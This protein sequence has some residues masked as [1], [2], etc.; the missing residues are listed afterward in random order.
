MR[1]RCSNARRQGVC[2]ASRRQRDG[3]TLERSSLSVPDRDHDAPCLEPVR[4]RRVIGDR[5]RRSRSQHIERRTGGC[6]GLV[7]R[8]ENVILPDGRDLE[9]RERAQPRDD[10]NGREARQ[11]RLRCVGSELDLD[12]ATRSGHAISLRVLDPYL[13]SRQ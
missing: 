7:S 1:V 13:E 8:D 6:H 5:E 3:L 10:G 2:G 12:L 4:S 11:R 9:V